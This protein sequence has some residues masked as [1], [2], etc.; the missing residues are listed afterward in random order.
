MNGK[1]FT[2]IVQ[3]NCDNRNQSSLAVTA[4]DLNDNVGGQIAVSGGTFA[5]HNCQNTIY[6]GINWVY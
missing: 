6:K 2:K 1:I 3:H 5:I 4:V